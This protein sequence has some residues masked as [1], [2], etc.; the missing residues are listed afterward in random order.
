MFGENESY[1]TLKFGVRNRSTPRPL[2][3]SPQ[4]SDLWPLD[5][6][7]ALDLYPA[8]ESSVRA[9]YRQSEELVA[10]IS[11][12]IGPERLGPFVGRH[13]ERGGTWRSTLRDEF[14]CTEVELREIDEAVRMRST[15]AFVE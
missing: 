2:G 10:A 12:T 9:F 4:A 5:D 14:D 3:E 8:E 11:R 13:L 1:I 15:S 6:L 7:T